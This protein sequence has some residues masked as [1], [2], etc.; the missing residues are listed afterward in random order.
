M[1]Q[2]DKTTRSIDPPIS[3]IQTGIGYVMKDGLSIE[4]PVFIDQIPKS[5]AALRRK[6]YGLTDGILG[7][8]PVYIIVDRTDTHLKIRYDLPTRLKKL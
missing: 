2:S 5:H 3:I 7:T 4:R 8:I 6:L 1:R